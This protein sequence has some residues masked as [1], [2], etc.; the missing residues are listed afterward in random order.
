MKKHSIYLN[1]TSRDLPEEEVDKLKNG[2]YAVTNFTPVT[3]GI[4]KN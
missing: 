4:I 3:N 2:I 1:H